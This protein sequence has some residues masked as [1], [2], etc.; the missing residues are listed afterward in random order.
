MPPDCTSRRRDTPK[1]RYR[2]FSRPADEFEAINL[3]RTAK[4][5]G[6]QKMP[7]ALPHKSRFVERQVTQRATY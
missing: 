4:T 6:E 5:N 1:L 3:C 7:I 2:S